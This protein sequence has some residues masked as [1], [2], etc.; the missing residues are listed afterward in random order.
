M[1]VLAGLISSFTALLTSDLDKVGLLTHWITAA[2][3]AGL[4]RLHARGLDQD[5]QAATAALTLPHH[6][7]RTEGRPRALIQYCACQA[8]AACRGEHAAALSLAWHDGPSRP[9]WSWP[10][11]RLG[12]GTCRWFYEGRSLAPAQAILQAAS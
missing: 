5:I 8:C 1:S 10:G 12:R 11:C 2:R 6:H 4:P 3:A 7:G 9:S